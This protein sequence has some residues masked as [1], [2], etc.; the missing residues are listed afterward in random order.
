MK[1]NIVEITKGK[2][3]T[4]LLIENDGY[5]SLDMPQNQSLCESYGLNE[6]E[7]RNLPSKLIFNAVFQKFD[8]P[9]ANGRVYPEDILKRE[10]NKY[11][12]AVSEKRAY[13]ELN[14]PSESSIDLGRIALNI[15]ELHWEGKTLVGKVAYR[16]LEL[17]AEAE[18]AK[19]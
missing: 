2:T 8:T 10:V 1:H 14:H 13:G 9:N 12:Q 19:Q 17:E 7:E 3:G 15:I 4:G 5:I 18:E 11:Q 6:G 16:T